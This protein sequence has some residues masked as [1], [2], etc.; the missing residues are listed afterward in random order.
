MKRK[1]LPILACACLFIGATSCSTITHSAQ[2][3]PVQTEV[4]SLATAD[5][6]VH[7]MKI[8]Y[9]YK[10][11]KAVRKGGDKN[12]LNMAVAEALRANYNTDVL[13][14]MQYEIKKTRNLFG[15]SKIKYVTVTGYPASYKN[16]TTAK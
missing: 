15:V 13:V 5:L 11:T 9:T 2:S 10:P 16:I 3:V 12:V 7:P 14:G 1:F 8:T 4:K 6:Y